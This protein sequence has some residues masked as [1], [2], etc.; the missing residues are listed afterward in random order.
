MKHVFSL[1]FLFGSL[2]LSAQDYHFSQFFANPL[3][4][5]PA[6]TGLFEGRYRVS[7]ASRSQWGQTL[8]TPYA[9]TAF[10]ADFHYFINPRKRQYKDAF[11]VGVNFVSDRLAEFNY[12]VNQIMISGAFHKSLDPRNNQYLSIGGQFGVVQRNVSYDGL[13]FDDAFDGTSV[14]VDGATLEAFPAN[15]YAFGDWQLGINYGFAPKNA[16]S[17]NLGLAMHHVG[18]PEQ[19]FY[20]ELTTGEEI[21]VTNLLPRRYSGYLNIGVPLNRDVLLSPRVYAFSQGPHVMINSG[22][23]IRFLIN[24][25]NGAALHLGAYARVVDS[26]SGLGLDSAVGMV[27]VE[28]SNFLIGLSYDVGLNGLQTSRRHQGAF[29]LNLAY[30][31][32]GSDDESV[33][34]P[35]F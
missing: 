34:C 21:V 24:D 3:S 20:N 35:R 29:E 19:S 10:N 22:S 11:G 28:L 33:P 27:G 7:L 23:N 12:S 1:L 14:F 8:E 25:S 32:K 6:L 13:T 18:E 30:L 9:T 4:L 16:T 26:V 15:N 17:V 31:G 2:S 5:N